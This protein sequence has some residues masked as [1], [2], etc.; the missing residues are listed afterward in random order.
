M[1]MVYNADKVPFHALLAKGVIKGGTDYSGTD[2]TGVDGDPPARIKPR[3]E[4]DA[5]LKAEREIQEGTEGGKR[6]RRDSLQL[7]YWATGQRGSFPPEHTR[8]YLAHLPADLIG[9]W[10]TGEGC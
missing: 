1:L 4:S 3:D 10:G 8:L 7:F 6:E 9:A 2:I 5:G